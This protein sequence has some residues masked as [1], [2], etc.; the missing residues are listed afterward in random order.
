MN[1]PP[2]VLDTGERAVKN[3]AQAVLATFAVGDLFNAFHADWGNAL[4]VGMGA[5]V[6]SVLTSIA[7][8][9][10]GTRGTASATSVVAPTPGKHEAP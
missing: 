6:L 1:L 3:F 4:G 5:A 2:F 8:F 10:V 9:N 7:S